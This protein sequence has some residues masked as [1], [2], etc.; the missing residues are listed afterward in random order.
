MLSAFGELCFFPGASLS[1]LSPLQGF[2][3]LI[4]LAEEAV[5]HLDYI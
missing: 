1:A 4:L 3:L 5:F 2:S